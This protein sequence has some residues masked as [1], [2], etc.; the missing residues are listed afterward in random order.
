MLSDAPAECDAMAD[1]ASSSFNTPSFSTSMTPPSSVIFSFMVS[2]SFAWLVAPW[3]KS[4]IAW[5]VFWML[6]EIYPNFSLNLSLLKLNVSP[7]WSTLPIIVA[8]DL[9]TSS[10]DRA[11]SPISSPRFINAG[12]TVKLKSPMAAW[13]RCP[14][15]NLMPFVI[16]KPLKAEITNAAPSI[17]TA[18]IP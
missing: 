8:N 14:S 2:V 17:R 9:R 7:V 10:K 18:A 3:A 1:T 6:W 11:I 12:L 4:S 5:L 15:T 16:L 13:R